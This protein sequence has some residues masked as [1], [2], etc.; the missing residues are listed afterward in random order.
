[1]TKSNK[2]NRYG[3]WAL[4][5]IALLPAGAAAQKVNQGID[6]STTTGLFSPN[7]FIYLGHYEHALAF[8]AANSVTQRE[9]SPTPI[10]WRVNG[11]D[12]HS[13]I[14]PYSCIALMSEYVLD[15]KKYEDG[16]TDK[17]WPASSIFYWLRDNFKNNFTSTEFGQ[18]RQG[19]VND[20]MYKLSNGDL[21]S[22]SGTNTPFYLLWGTPSQSTHSNR[23]KLF[24][25]RDRAGTSFVI[26][27]SYMKLDDEHRVATLKG[28]IPGIGGVSYWLRPP[29]ESM[30]AQ[31]LYVQPHGTIDINGF[32][33]L[34][35]VRPLCILDTAKVLFAAELQ[36]TNGI[37]RVDQ[38]VA[39]NAGIY[40][41]EDAIPGGG[42]GKSAYK[43]TLL[44]TTLTPITQLDYDYDESVAGITDTV[45]LKPSELLPLSVTPAGISAAGLAYK[46]VSNPNRLRHY[47][48][49]AGTGTLSVLASRCRRALCIRCTPGRKT[50]T[51]RSRTKVLRCSP[52]RCAY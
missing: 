52:S 17:A 25:S 2:I 51:L 23:N 9:S 6:M 4:L 28:G 3:L 8:D 15:S 11:L 39:D 16:S 1:M 13:N 26:D 24:W 34:N 27:E 14:S 43:L 38:I 40:T 42:A 49:T 44:N 50:T 48:Y 18:V 7:N 36:E 32:G 45:A 31:K 47:N 19:H 37:D 20:M 29:L 41:A 12:D 22:L 46:V 10:L 21:S 35:G 5:L 30:T 33:V